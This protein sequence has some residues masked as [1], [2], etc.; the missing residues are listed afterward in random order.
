VSPCS[1]QVAGLESSF[2]WNRL[3]YEYQ[4][5]GSERLVRHSL[6]W[7]AYSIQAMDLSQ[8]QITSL[9]YPLII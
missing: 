8:W 4:T 6:D 3:V 5:A 7:V 9:S 2:H 1:L